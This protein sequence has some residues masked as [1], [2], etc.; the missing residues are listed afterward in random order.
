MRWPLPFVTRPSRRY[1]KLKRERAPS[2]KKQ[3]ACT[4]QVGDIRG[5]LVGSDSRFSSWPKWLEATS[6]RTAQRSFFRSDVEKGPRRRSCARC[7]TASPRTTPRGAE[8]RWQLV[9]SSISTSHHAPRAA[10]LHGIDHCVH[11][12]LVDDAP[13]SHSDVVRFTERSVLRH[14]VTSTD[15]SIPPFSLLELSQAIHIFYGHLKGKACA[16]G[17]IVT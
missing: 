14:H 1:P 16:P 2:S 9:Q 13:R 3:E 12:L 17:T 7:R 15:R 6:A 8:T 4:A 5:S 11:S 10:A